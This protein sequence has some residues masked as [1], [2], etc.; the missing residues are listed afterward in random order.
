MKLKYSVD[1][2]DFVKYDD[3]VIDSFKY[4]AQSRNGTWAAFNYKPV[5]DKE[6]SIWTPNLTLSKQCR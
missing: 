1:H 2:L 3:N 5:V 6:L 4:V